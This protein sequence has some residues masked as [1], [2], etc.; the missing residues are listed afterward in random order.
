MGISPLKVGDT[1][2]C[3]S[4]GKAEALSAQFQSVFTREDLTSKPTLD[5]SSIPDIPP[6]HF[7]T[8]G[9]AKLLSNVD[10]KKASGPDNIPCQVLK[11]SAQYIAPY[12]QVIYSQSY[13]TGTLPQDWLTAN[14]TGIYKKGD[15]SK[16]E[17]YRPVS[18]TSVPCK[19]MEHILFHHIM[20]HLD[21][22]Q[23]IV[24]YQHGFRRAHSCETQLVTTVEEIARQ[25]DS[26]TQVDLLILDFSKAFDTVAH[27]RLLD[28]IDHYGIRGPIKDWIG[29]WLTNRTQR[30][31]V[32]GDSSSATDVL[33][34][35]P[36]GTVLGPL[37]FLLYV[38][39]IGD[40]VTSSI[41]LFADDCLLVR[42]IHTP[43]DAEAL[44]NDLK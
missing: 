13:H 31:V 33:S 27:E 9:I 14:V 29:R 37:M 38:N 12:L 4:K 32:D 43:E 44:Q 16:C 39:D 36:Q 35:V 7:H 20:E 8:T 2:V 23:I 15:K 30:V 17:N 22:H 40:N 19:I 25:L 24:K 18:L 28:K 41:K 21:H 42:T 6:L 10:P 1:T 5:H 11:E 34:G 26:R 3:S